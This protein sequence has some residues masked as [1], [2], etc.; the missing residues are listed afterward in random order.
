MDLAKLINVAHERLILSKSNHRELLAS[1]EPQ[2]VRPVVK[3][4]QQLFKNFVAYEKG[5]TRSHVLNV[6]KD[7]IWPLMDAE[8]RSD[9][10]SSVVKQ[11]LSGPET[12]FSQKSIVDALDAL[13]IPTG[14]LILFLS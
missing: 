3:V 8:E 10:F 13:R 1:V 4:A 6:I 5:V 14:D 11:F 9:L 2:E 7:R 12:G